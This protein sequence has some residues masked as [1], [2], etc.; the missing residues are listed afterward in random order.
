MNTMRTRCAHAARSPPALQALT[1]ATSW[2]KVESEKL[3]AR[4]GGGGG[5]GGGAPPAVTEC[6]WSWKHMRRR[7]VE[8]P[9]SP[10][11]P[12]PTWFAWAAARLHAAWAGWWA[13][14]Y[15]VWLPATA[16]V[17]ALNAVAIVSVVLILRAAD[18]HR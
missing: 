15:D 14:W 11:P 10:P 3:Q 8:P 4:S 5:G 7:C 6:K 16:K 17:C 1:D 9:P 18:A 13:T 2:V 12:P